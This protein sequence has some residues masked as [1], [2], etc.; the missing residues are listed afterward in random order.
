MEGLEKLFA[1]SQ[2]R[3][4]NIKFKGVEIKLILRDL[5][6]SQKTKILNQ[7]LVFKDTGTISV[8]I[9]LYN[10]TMLKAIIVQAPWGETNDIFLN[11]VN[12]E[13]GSELEKLIPKAFEEFSSS[14]FLAKEQSK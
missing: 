7:C 12:Q 8:D 5:A 9:D 11:Q 3:E 13:F 1:S 4:V 6:W 2:P 10:K 14:D